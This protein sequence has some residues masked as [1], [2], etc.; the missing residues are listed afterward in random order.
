MWLDGALRQARLFNRCDIVLI[1]EAGAIGTARPDPSLNVTCVPVEEIGLSPKHE[2]FRRSSPLDRSFRDGFW[3][4]TSERFFVLESAMRQ[5][6]L[7][8]VVHIEND[9]MLYVDCA[10]LV[11][12]LARLYPTAIGATFDNDARCVPGIL[13]VPT[14]EQ[15]AFLTE[16][17]LTAFRNLGPKRA[18]GL[19]DMAVLGALRHYWP[20]TID[21]LPIVP[22]DYPAPLR[23]AAG[24]RATTPTAYWKNFDSLGMIF[25]AAALGQFLGGIDPRNAPG[26]TAGFVNESC[27]FDPRLLRPQLVLDEEGRRVPVVHSASGRHRV[28]N[29]HIHSKNTHG[30]LSA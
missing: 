16:F 12:N 11:D 28:A 5:L 26:P 18:A 20:Q 23:S 15:A 19:N 7:G 24:H 25:D 14:P 29:L 9:V 30:F 8:R 22:P 17:Y 10:A 21:H 3:T 4:F 1:A 2:E 27:V 6:R 13:Y